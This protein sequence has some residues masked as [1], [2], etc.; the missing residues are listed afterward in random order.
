MMVKFNFGCGP[1]VLKGESDDGYTL[2]TVELND[3]YGEISTE[4]IENIA[5]KLYSTF[6]VNYVLLYRDNVCICII[7]KKEEEG[8]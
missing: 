7:D 1:L 6:Y 8:K 5:K 3:P 2:I 4:V